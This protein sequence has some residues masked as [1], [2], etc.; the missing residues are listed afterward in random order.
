MSVLRLS[1]TIRRKCQ[2]SIA[3]QPANT[4]PAMCFERGA[5]RC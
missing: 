2:G 5:L 3:G 1:Y 4:L